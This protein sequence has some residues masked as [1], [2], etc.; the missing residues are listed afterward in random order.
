MLINC[1][2]FFILAKKKMFSFNHFPDLVLE[3]MVLFM[4]LP[5]LCYIVWELTRG[6]DKR[7]Y[8]K[9]YK[10]R[11]FL[12]IS[13]DEIWKKWDHETYT[14]F[15]LFIYKL[16]KRTFFDEFCK[17]KNNLSHFYVYFRGFLPGL[18]CIL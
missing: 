14:P 1:C 3:K 2:C 12:K 10:C 9:C 4:D 8:N 16:T 15:Y 13:I 6:S 11:N 7:H 17:N 18:V 5:E